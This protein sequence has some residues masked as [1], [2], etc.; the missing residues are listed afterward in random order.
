MNG[1]RRSSHNQE[2]AEGTETT[3]NRR[4]TACG[5]RLLTT[6]NPQRVLKHFN[7]AGYA[8]RTVLLTTK[9]PQRVLK[10]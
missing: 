10:R 6:K 8:T 9:N 5:S 3:I 4:S 7:A 2:P 1:R